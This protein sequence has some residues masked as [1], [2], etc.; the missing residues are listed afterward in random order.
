MQFFDVLERYFPAHRL[1]TSDF[2][3]LPNATVGLNAPIVQTRYQRQPVP[4]ST[5]LVSLC[6]SA[7]IYSMR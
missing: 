4:V 6:I 3:S 7:D 1:V 5:P 2:H